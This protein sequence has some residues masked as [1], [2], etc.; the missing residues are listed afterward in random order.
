MK[1]KTKAGVQMRKII[2]SFC[3]KELRQVLRV[4]N[5]CVGSLKGKDKNA[6][7]LPTGH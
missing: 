1:M 4:Q 7:W 5:P 3:F 2:V 6:I